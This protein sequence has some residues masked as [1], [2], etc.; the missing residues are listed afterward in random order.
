[1]HP[2]T[3]RIIPLVFICIFTYAYF[4][5][6]KLYDTFTDGVKGV[7]PLCLS[8]FPYLVTI[9]IMTSLFEKSGISAFLTQKLAPV[10]NFLGIPKELSRLVLIKPFSGTGSFAHLSELFKLYGPDSYIS[11]CA[12][13]IYGST[14]TIFYM[15]A[16]YFAQYKNFKIL[17]PILIS[18]ACFILSIIF[19][20][21][22]CKVL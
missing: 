20:A 10:F 11:R 5:K 9:F 17:K 4:K 16:M 19:S 7:F 13:V 2:I 21:F 1:M 15:S 12:C 22:I 6:V 8:I 3:I 14:D 18:L